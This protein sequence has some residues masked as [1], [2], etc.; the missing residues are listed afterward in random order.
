M[1]FTF[2]YGMMKRD[3][4]FV[5]CV[6]QALWQVSNHCIQTQ[7]IIIKLLPLWLNAFWVNCLRSISFKYE[8]IINIYIMTEIKNVCQTHK[9]PT[10]LILFITIK[11][12]KAINDYQKQ[13]CAGD[14]MRKQRI[15]ELSILFALQPTVIEQSLSVRNYKHH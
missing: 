15:S 9:R 14:I 3:V 7:L 5:I 2:F 4:T 10:D 6:C 13:E 12:F 1:I 8:K 11:L